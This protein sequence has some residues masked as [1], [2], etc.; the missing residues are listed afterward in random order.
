VIFAQGANDPS[1]ATVY[2]SPDL[3]GPDGFGSL[4]VND[5]DGTIVVPAQTSLIAPAGGAIT[6]DGANILVAGH[7]SAPAGQIAL[8]AHNVSPSL[9]AALN[10]NPSA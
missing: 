7:L 9:L 6:L 8:T 4:A 2:L 5:S 1:G 3:L 10:V